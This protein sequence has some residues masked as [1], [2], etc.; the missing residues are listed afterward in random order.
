MAFG[1][2]EVVVVLAVIGAVGVALGY[3]PAVPVVPSTTPTRRSGDPVPPRRSTPPQIPPPHLPP[4]PYTV[5][6]CFGTLPVGSTRLLFEIRPYAP[7]REEGAEVVYFGRLE[8]FDFST[9][10]WVGVGGEIIQFWDPA[11]CT[12]FDWTACDPYGDYELSRPLQSD[13]R[14]GYSVFAVYGGWLAL[15]PALTGV[16]AVEPQ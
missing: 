5:Q 4:G 12:M 2:G 3:K 1:G 15:D 13:E 16:L 14:D 10:H 11:S 7:I 9:G 6:D 8:A